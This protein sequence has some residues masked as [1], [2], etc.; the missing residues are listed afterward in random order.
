MFKDTKFFFICYSNN[1]K[2]IQKSV[3]FNDFHLGFNSDKICVLKS[4][5]AIHLLWDLGL[6]T[7]L[8]WS[9]LTLE[10]AHKTSFW[11]LFF[12]EYSSCTWLQLEFFG[13]GSH[14]QIFFPENLDLGLRDNRE[15]W[16]VSWSWRVITFLWYM[17]IECAMYT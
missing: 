10:N 2:L 3:K 12:H 15:C 1:G 13:S 4:Y 8:L 6:T 5:F 17:K 16:L 11:A 14:S 9:I 7:Q